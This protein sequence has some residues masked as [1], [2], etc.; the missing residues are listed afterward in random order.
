M[1]TKLIAALLTTATALLAVE[2][3][4]PAYESE[5]DKLV[6][7]RKAENS[8]LVVERGICINLEK[9]E[10]I[11]DAITTEI[12]EGGIS[13]FAVISFNSGHDYEALFKAYATPTRICKAIESLGTKRGRPVDYSSLTFWSKGE[14]Y[15]VSVKYNGVERPIS[16]YIYDVNQKKIMDSITFV[17]LGS[18]WNKSADGEETFAG[19][20]EGPGSIVSMYNEPLSVFDIP[21][22]APQGQ[23][24]EKSLVSKNVI[25]NEAERVEIILRPEA[26]PVSAPNR[27]VDVVTTL[28]QDGISID[29]A[30]AIKPI[31]FV[32]YLNDKLTLKQDVYAQLAFAENVSLTDIAAFA[33]LIDSLEQKE[34]IKVEAPKNN[35]YYKAFLPQEAWLKR[36]DRLAQPLELHISKVENQISKKLIAIKEVW[37]D[38]SQSI[39]PTLEPKEYEI[40]QVT[41]VAEL[42]VQAESWKRD[43]SLEDSVFKNYIASGKAPLLVFAPT[44]LTFMEL[45]AELKPLQKTH[46]NIFIFIGKQIIE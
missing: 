5:L 46:S 21:K 22:N 26:R 39:N 6:E 23:V 18:K 7:K 40:N 19:D 43:M 30:E 12:K 28:T 3:D 9:K 36:S 27:N 35:I 29:S 2:I 11:L 1:K 45:Q 41:N 34:L 24:Y 42:G 44:N 33:V 15:S 16:D 32:K 14:H 25:S 4:I 31:D 20:S 17:Y 13:E 37:P 8:Q 10:I 38:A